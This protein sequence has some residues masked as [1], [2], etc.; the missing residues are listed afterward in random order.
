MSG[1]LLLAA[2]GVGAVR[3]QAVGA[4]I[5]KVKDWDPT[6]HPRG[7]KGM[8][9]ETPNKKSAGDVATGAVIAT[10]SGKVFQVT[11]HGP[12]GIKVQSVDPDTGA[13]QAK[14]T[15]VGN[16][17]EVAVFEDKTAPSIQTVPKTGVS[18]PHGIGSKY[19]IGQ[20]VPGT[21]IKHP[22]SG[23]RFQVGKQGKWTTVYPVDSNGERAGKHT[24]LPPQTDVIVEP[25]EV[26]TGGV[27]QTHTQAIQNVAKTPQTRPP[28]RASLRTGKVTQ[29]PP[30]FDVDDIAKRISDGETGTIKEVRFN[31][32]IIIDW[33]DGGPL[34]KIDPS[35][36]EKVIPEIMPKFDKPPR[37]YAPGTGRN[38][39]VVIEEIAEL[40]YF[41]GASKDVQYVIKRVPDP[42]KPGDPGEALGTYNGIGAARKA[43]RAMSENHEPVIET[44]SG[45]RDYKYKVG[46]WGVFDGYVRQVHSVEERQ[47]YYGTGTYQALQYVDN[48]T[49]SPRSI[50]V[51][52]HIPILD[53]QAL[54]KFAWD[55]HGATLTSG[56]RIYK[57][58]QS[59]ISGGDEILK[60]AM[61][62]TAGDP[63]VVRAARPNLYVDALRTDFDPSELVGKPKGQVLSAL[64][65]AGYAEITPREPNMTKYVN[66]RGRRLHIHNKGGNVTAMDEIKM[67][68]F[69]SGSS[70]LRGYHAQLAATLQS[71][72]DVRPLN[73]QNDPS[74]EARTSHTRQLVFD[75]ALGKQQG[76][77]K[78]FNKDGSTLK[79][80]SD[81]AYRGE[82]QKDITEGK[83]PDLT[84]TALA[85]KVEDPGLNVP[86]RTE[87]MDKHF[88]G[89]KNQ[90]GIT[91]T[92]NNLHIK[93][94]SEHSLIAASAIASGERNGVAEW[95]AK[96]YG[97]DFK[98]AV[99]SFA[100]DYA[101]WQQ[102]PG[103]PDTTFA[104][105]SGGQRD[106]LV[107]TLKD[108]EPR[109]VR[110]WG[111][112]ETEMQRRIDSLREQGIS[113]E[114][115]KRRAI[116]G[117]VAS[118]PGSSNTF[119]LPLWDEI[120][121]QS[122]DLGDVESL[123]QNAPSTTQIVPFFFSG[124][125]VDDSVLYAIKENRGSTRI[126]GRVPKHFDRLMEQRLVGA[127]VERNKH[128]PN[129]HGSSGNRIDAGVQLTLHESGGKRIEYVP[130]NLH[131]QTAV[132]SQ[133]G[134]IRM[135]GYTPEEA[136]ARLKDLG[137]VHDVEGEVP[138]SSIMRSR[139]RY[140]RVLPLYSDYVSGDAPLPKI[141][142]GIS[143]GMNSSNLTA[144][145]DSGGLLPLAERF[146]VGIPLSGTIPRNDIAGGVDHVVFAAI[147]GNY[148]GYGDVSVLYK[149]SAYLRRN[150]LIT[151]R[152][153]SGSGGGN[154][155]YPAYRSYHNK[156]RRNAGVADAD[157]NIYAAMEPAA[158]Q[159]HINERYRQAGNSPTSMSASQNEWDL[160][161]GV[162]IEDI[163]AIAVPDQRTADRLNRQLDTMLAA[164]RISER[165]EVEV[166]SSYGG[167]SPWKKAERTD[168]TVVDPRSIGRR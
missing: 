23:K 52:Q 20:L 46:D 113:T 163:A 16:N 40:S 37:T 45:V 71:G 39:G 78:I 36:F 120:E 21:Y 94:P 19:E 130:H 131:R 111:L 160:E 145:V 77:E 32:D 91:W 153:F 167:Y 115:S 57:Y 154:G 11:G 139:R 105:L 121:F 100:L 151:D 128:F 69:S 74:A 28:R 162:P 135:Y 137:I 2:P 51:D 61:A 168:W 7:Y 26:T 140:G 125:L 88:P 103:D 143:H 107:S 85:A 79:V 44:R 13:V 60:R 147:S 27:G 56:M 24:V 157:Q 4:V 31:G 129:P 17:V 117:T 76:V 101:E 95:V 158:R 50:G 148:A 73:P 38:T 41:G 126:D 68:T 124:G 59:D 22:R 63:K 161:G 156:H 118:V 42:D 141:P 109:A 164:G 48:P 47:S 9:I 166:N 12:K 155:R 119:E 108:V 54:N 90:T 72:G 104:K 116:E 149:D 97:T 82:I 150:V 122:Q 3:S 29:A 66:D 112:R 81:A 5:F 75:M 152:V 67:P 134:Q 87:V 89:W 58:G 80:K 165:P 62:Q 70:G 35:E 146:R 6:R 138:Y 18:Q 65:K 123:I 102:D 127:R 93:D 142:A 86:L 10:K 159:S 49:A 84:P 34:Q 30:T 25:K 96:E 53:F 1:N 99:E 83:L 33:G 133:R 15:I 43:A 110:Q 132:A 114:T 64:R 55:N 8:F 14:G 136:A 92:G 106:Y 144:V 98:T